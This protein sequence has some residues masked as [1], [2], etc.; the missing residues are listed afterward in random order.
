MKLSTLSSLVIITLSLFQISCMQ[1]DKKQDPY[2]EGDIV[3]WKINNHLILKAEVGQRREHSLEN[4]S[5]RGEAEFYRPQYERYLGQFPIDYQPIGFDKISES[6]ARDMPISKHSGRRYE[7]NLMLNGSTVQASDRVV[8][9]NDTLDHPDQVKVV[10]NS[11]QA[12][13]TTK[14]ATEKEEREVKAKYEK[15]L[16]EKYGLHCRTRDDIG[17]PHCFGNSIN[18]QVSGIVFSFWNDEKIKAISYEPIYGGI[19]VEWYFHPSNLQHWQEIDTAIW[20][21]IETWNISPI[22]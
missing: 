20:D 13:L 11:Y 21:L 5:K 3:T 1:Q 9:S 7:F 14:E 12:S 4:H 6:E 2:K 10:I 19:K 16:S 8:E 15:E 18:P 17:I 22:E